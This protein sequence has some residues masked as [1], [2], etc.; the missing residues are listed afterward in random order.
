MIQALVL[1]SETLVR[2]RVI[3]QR[4]GDA[5]LGIVK[6]MM[7]DNLKEKMRNGVAHF[8]FAKKN[9]EV[10]EAWGTLN[11]AIVA[12]HTTGT[13]ESREY[14]YTTAYFDVERGAWRSFRWESLI[15]VF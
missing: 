3:G 7:I 4:T 11:R 1:K 5:T 9:G 15:T 2:T 10:R 14:Y 8:I 6:A 13:G 12:K